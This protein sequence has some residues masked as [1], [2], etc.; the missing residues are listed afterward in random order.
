VQ[1]PL[2]FSQVQVLNGNIILNGGVG[3][4]G[5]PYNILASTNLTLPLAQWTPVYTNYF[6]NAG[7]FSYT[8]SIDPGTPQ[9]FYR[10]RLP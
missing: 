1:A 9:K 10:V 7:K 8:N 4:P 5:Q 2:Q 6:D 3:T